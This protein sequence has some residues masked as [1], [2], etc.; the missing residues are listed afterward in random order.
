LLV[1]QLGRFNLLRFAALVWLGAT[2]GSVPSVLAKNAM[3]KKEKERKIDFPKSRKFRQKT[4]TRH[5]FEK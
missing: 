3:A 4:L 1:I 5:F 2:I